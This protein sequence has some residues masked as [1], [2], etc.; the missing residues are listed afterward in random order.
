LKKL[1]LIIS[2][3]YE[4]NV[5]KLISRLNEKKINWI[6]FNTEK[7][8]LLANGT[9]RLDN[10]NDLN[11]LFDFDNK[12]VNVNEITSVWY[13]RFGK[14]VLPDSFTEQ[15]RIFTSGESQTFLR[16]LFQSINAF[17]VNPRDSEVKAND[18]PFQLICA[19]EVGFQIPKTIIT[20]D[21]EEVLK[22]YSQSKEQIIFKPLSG[23]SYLPVDYTTEVYSAYKNRFNTKPFIDKQ[24]LKNPVFFTQILDDEK[25]KKI[26]NV[27]FCPVIFQE[28]IKKKYE[29]RITIV[30]KQIFACAIYSQ[31]YPETSIDFRKF[32]ILSNQI[33]PHKKVNLPL[34]IQQKILNLMEKLGL[35]FGCIDMIVT[36][37]DQYVF[38]EINPSGQWLWIEEFTGY[39]ITNALVDLLTI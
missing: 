9:W 19:K 34:G 36:P 20:N 22:F 5:N 11:L 27:Q 26:Q 38:L 21:P 31:D 29:L 4:P 18:K 23:I 33:P 16:S 30:G 14:F 2:H 12:R 39:K 10:S 15:E 13:R 1:V 3:F 32:A 37:D 25:I 17:W 35:V 24:Q 7:F 8:P 6:R 28:F